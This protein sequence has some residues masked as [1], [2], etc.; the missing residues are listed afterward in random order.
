MVKNQENHWLTFL[1]FVGSRG[2][3]ILFLL[4][5]KILKNTFTGKQSFKP[6]IKCNVECSLT[7]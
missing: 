6:Q 2:K 3:N 7:N 5:L 4:C 1:N